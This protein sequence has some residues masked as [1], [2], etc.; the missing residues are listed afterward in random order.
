MSGGGPVNI[1]LIGVRGSGKS[2]VGRR[3]AADGGRPFC[4]M[5]TELVR[6]FGRSIQEF[7]HA[8]GWAAFRSAEKSLLR[9]LAAREG[10]VV[11]TG[12]GV[13]LDEG[14]IE[15]MCRSGRVVWL[16]AEPE[17][18][19][20]RLQTD[21]GMGPQRPALTPGLGLAEEVRQTLAAREPL[22]RRAMGWDVV[23][24]GLSVAAVCRIIMEHLEPRVETGGA[25]P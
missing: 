7:V 15:D 18:L 24:D 22:Y 14:N 3:L 16:R 10:L 23:T 21:E 8:Q 12:G 19:L 2:A 4:D 6:R 11:S 5:D 25:F 17:T 9:E 20:K 1:Y 13:V